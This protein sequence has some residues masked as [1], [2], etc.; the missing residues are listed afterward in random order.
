ML[1]IYCRVDT[2]NTTTTTRASLNPMFFW[3][4]NGSSTYY[5][6]LA[7]CIFFFFFFHSIL[8]EVILCYFLYWYIIFYNLYSRYIGSFSTL[9]HSLNLNQI[10][11]SPPFPSFFNPYISIYF[12]L[13]ILTFLFQLC[14]FYEYFAS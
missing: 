9:F 1:L 8:Y 12:Y 6:G 11:L 5:L 7:T 10:T 3:A 4:S 14:S 2:S 13:F